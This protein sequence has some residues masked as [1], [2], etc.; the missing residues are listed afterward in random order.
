MAPNVPY[1]KA[2]PFPFVKAN[3]L[4]PRLSPRTAQIL[5]ATKQHEEARIFDFCEP[6]GIGFSTADLR[7]PFATRTI[8][9]VASDNVR[10]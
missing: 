3:V 10:F 2:A 5:V 8:H 7:V 1:K 6:A 9:G 4:N